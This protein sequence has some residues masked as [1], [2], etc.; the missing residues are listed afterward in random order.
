MLLLYDFLWCFFIYGLLGW[1]TEVAFAAVKSGKFVNRGFLNGPI[2]PVYGVGVGIVVFLLYDYRDRIVLLYVLSTILV[3]FIEWL[4]G[5]LMDKIFHHKWW[6][7]SHMP[8]NIG[9]YVCLLFSLVWGVACVF[10]VKVIHPLIARIVGMIPI[11]AGVVILCVLVGATC[12]DICVTTLRVLKMNHHLD[13]MERVAEE[14]KELSDK[15]GE[16]I[17]ENVMEQHERAEKLREKYTELAK[18]STHLGSRFVKAFPKMQ[19][20]R[21]Q[22]LLEEIRQN[23]KK[24]RR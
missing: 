13:M 2:C 20:R 6:D 12:A 4:T 17:Y 15:L 24:G 5:Y 18:T 22:D 9:G 14:L 8:L 21:H 19:S 3:T 11:T 10:I 16:K 7:Y 1:C 23:L